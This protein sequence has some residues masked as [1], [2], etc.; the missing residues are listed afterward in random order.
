M[1]FH[2]PR[3]KTLAGMAAVSLLALA[4]CGDDADAETTAAEGEGQEVCGTDPL[5]FSDTGVEGLEVLQLEFEEFRAALEEATGLEV[6]FQPMSSRTAAATALE[7]DDLDV[8]LTGPAEYV[9]LQAESDQLNPAERM[10]GFSI[11][12]QEE[13]AESWLESGA[14]ADHLSILGREVGKID[15]YIDVGL[16]NAEVLAEAADVEAAYDRNEIRENGLNFFTQLASLGPG[17]SG[18]AGDVIAHGLAEMV[19]E[20]PADYAVR[21]E[22]ADTSQT[23]LPGGVVTGLHVVSELVDSG[24]VDRGPAR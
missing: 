8:L 7:Y 20:D 15:G 18:T 12:W 3:S 17:A 6:E 19:M 5:R 13:M 4:A 11:A 10:N 24:E 2:A 16:Q 23:P 21:E 22:G 9:V 1:R 14:D